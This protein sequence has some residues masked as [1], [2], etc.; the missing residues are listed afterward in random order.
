VYRTNAIVA[1]IKLIIKAAD[2]E[3]GD[4]DCEFADI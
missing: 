4:G 3:G 2:C 1:E